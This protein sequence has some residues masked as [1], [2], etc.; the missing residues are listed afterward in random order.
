MRIRHT[1]S[2]PLLAATLLFLLAGVLALHRPADAVLLTSS[3]L[4]SCVQQQYS[5]GPVTTTCRNRQAVK[6]TVANGA[7]VKFALYS[8]S[9]YDAQGY[10][11]G[12][13][14]A[15]YTL[16]VSKSEPTWSYPLRYLH[17]V[18]YAPREELIKVPN[19]RPG[20]PACVDSS[21][22][23]VTPTCGWQLDGGG[24]PIPDSQGFCSNRDLL[25]LKTNSDPQGWWRGEKELGVQST[26]ANSFSIAHCLRESGVSYRGYE[27]DPPVREFAI[28]ID[29]YDGDGTTLTLLRSLSLTPDK[30]R[31]A[32]DPATPHQLQATLPVKEFAPAPPLN[33]SGYI[34]YVPSGPANDPKVLDWT[35]NLLLLPREMVS[36][37]GRDCDKVGTGYSAF[38]GEAS[39][40]ATSGAGACLGNQLQQLQ[41]ADQARL[42]ASPNAETDYLLSGKK[43][44]KPGLAEMAALERPALLL[45][46]PELV[47]TTVGLEM[48]PGF[49]RLVTNDAVGWIKDAMVS[50]YPSLTREGVMSVTVENVGT[51]TTNYTVTVTDCSPAIEAVSPLSQTVA[52][53]ASVTL[54]FP[55]RSSSDMNGSHYCYLYLSNPL[56]AR[57]YDNVKVYFDTTAVSGK[58]PRD[59]L[60][61]NGNS[62]VKIP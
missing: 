38:R 23:N 18:D 33:L 2:S 6:V 31:A 35:N 46:S 57:V 26:Q 55:L 40:V 48:D 32:D 50:P 16:N 54:N 11:T 25:T 62:T 20:I 13:A 27:I 41:A 59:L 3:A 34:L 19:S 10:P 36:R 15:I 14:T 49:I 53:G 47:N 39:T 51:S 29:V 1:S 60:L 7:P 43:M 42:A 61:K 44:F 37:D 17:T 12:T 9:Q 4:K 22:A 28:N 52:A 30:P 58:A 21:D 45:K 8:S 5:S 56:T 24:K